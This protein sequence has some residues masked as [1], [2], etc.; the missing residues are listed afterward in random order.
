MWQ[1]LILLCLAEAKIL[2][3]TVDIH[4]FIS[5]VTV[6]IKMLTFD[7]KMKKI[8]QVELKSAVIFYECHCFITS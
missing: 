2:L 5:V 7:N 6:I 1:F 4:T 3:Q 8:I